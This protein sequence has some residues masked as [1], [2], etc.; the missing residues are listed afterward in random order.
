[1][2]DGLIYTINHWPKADPCSQAF[3]LEPSDQNM[4]ESEKSTADSHNMEIDDDNNTKT[5]PGKESHHRF[6]KRTESVVV[7]TGDESEIKR[8]NEQFFGRDGTETTLALEQPELAGPPTSWRSQEGRFSQPLNEAYPLAQRPHLLKPFAKKEHLFGAS[9]STD[10]GSEMEK[11]EGRGNRARLSV[12]YS[13][14]IARY[15]SLPF[16]LSLSLSLS[17]FLSLSLLITH[18]FVSL[19]YTQ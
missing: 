4:E 3:V 17:L 18:L 14:P 6:F 16:S 2:L 9:L 15:S 7:A 12:S 11:S 1:M 8:H 10:V 5:T 13:N 19:S